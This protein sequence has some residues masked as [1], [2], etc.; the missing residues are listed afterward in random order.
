MRVLDLFCGAGGAA[1][2]YAR[3]GFGVVGVDIRPQPRYPFPFVQADAMT[4]AVN[5]LEFDLI[6]AS[7]PCQLFSRA[8]KLREAQGGQPSTL[9]LLTPTRTMLQEIG[10]PYVIENVPGSPMDGVSIC[11]SSFGLDVRRH[12]LFESAL[13]LMALPCRHSA[14]GRPVGVYHVMGDEIPQ[15]GRTAKTLDEAQTAMG[16]DWMEWSE[17]KEAVPPA[18]TEFIGGQLI[19]YL[20]KV[21]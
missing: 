3:A 11:G 10:V 2:G 18:Y 4:L 12:R 13:P 6:H 8:G 16:I 7:P 1:M 20:R 15:G 14:Q 19:E 9:D 5:P 21:A 17:L